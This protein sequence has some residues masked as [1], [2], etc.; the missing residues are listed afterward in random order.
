MKFTLFAITLLLLT[1]CSSSVAPTSTPPPTF[2]PIPTVLPTS[3]PTQSPTETLTPTQTQTILPTVTLPAEVAHLS[4]FALSPKGDLLAV[5][6][7]VGVLLLNAT[8]WQETGRLSGGEWV[9][10]V[11]FVPSP[12][13]A[14]PQLAVAT[15]LGTVEVW[16]PASGK[17]AATLKEPGASPGPLTALAASPD[18]RWLATGALDAKVRLWNLQTQKLARTL[19]YLSGPVMSVAFSPDS[20]TVAAGGVTDCAANLVIAAWR[21]ATGQRVDAPSGV[22]STVNAVVYSPD[23]KV[24]ASG[25][26]DGVGYLEPLSGGD[27]LEL[28]SHQGEITALAFSPDGQLVASGGADNNVMLWNAQTG[29]LLYTLTGHADKIASVAFSVDSE[30][31]L[32]A[33]VDGDLRSWNVSSGELLKQQALFVPIT[34]PPVGCS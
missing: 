1:A 27:P 19:E 6:T 5:G 32:S 28:Y 3:T 17:L 15:Q 2:A 12:N 21:V 20:H 4:Q 24:L 31:L 25:G 33:S 9:S 26:A 29:D 16:D 22:P 7:S 14:D 23:G 10:G 8:T 30:T 11:A 18:G 13:G 34:A